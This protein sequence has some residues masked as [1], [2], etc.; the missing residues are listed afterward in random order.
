MA[1]A[2]GQRRS[3]TGPIVL[4][5]VGSIVGLL[6]LGLLAGG[7]L[8]LWADKTQRD[9]TGYFTSHR[10]HF[11]SG[12]YAITREG[13]KLTGIPSG[14][15]ASEGR[16]R[17]RYSRYIARIGCHVGIEKSS[18]NPRSASSASTTSSNAVLRA[19]LLA[20]SARSNSYPFGPFTTVRRRSLT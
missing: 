5:V 16:Q 4:I 8:V 17:C 11:V 3:R 14:I 6:A 19:L 2:E 15:D 9:S 18:S 20:L 12:T 13:A 1:A 7:G 10:H